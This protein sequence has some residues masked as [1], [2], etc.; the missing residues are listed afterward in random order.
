MTPITTLLRKFNE[1]ESVH[2]SVNPSQH[3]GQPYRRFHGKTGVIVAKQGRAYLVQIKDQ[4][5]TKQVIVSAPHLKR[6][7]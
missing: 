3:K 5:A 7:V 4:N 6:Q 2:I 1:G